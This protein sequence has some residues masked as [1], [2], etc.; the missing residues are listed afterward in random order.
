MASDVVET[1]AQTH[2]YTIISS[3]APLAAPRPAMTITRNGSGHAIISWSADAGLFKVQ[4]TTS[5]TSPSWTDVTS[6]NVA[7]PVDAG[8]IGAT[9]TYFQLIR[10]SKDLLVGLGGAGSQPHASFGEVVT[11]LPALWAGSFFYRPEA[12]SCRRG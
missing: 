12:G 11:T 4:K 7:T 1:L 10:Q 9:P 5:L 8:A 3:P 6:G 2:C